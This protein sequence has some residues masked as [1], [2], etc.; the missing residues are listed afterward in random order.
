[1]NHATEGGGQLAEACNSDLLR[2][3]QD[4]LNRKHLTTVRTL[5][6]EE[7]VCEFPDRTCT[8]TDEIVA[9][10]EESFIAMP[11]RHVEVIAMVESGEDV[12]MRFRLT[13]TQD[14]PFGDLPATGKALVID[15]FEHFVM[16]DGRLV[17]SYAV[18][19]QLNVARQLGMIGPDG[20]VGDKLMKFAFRLKTNLSRR[21]KSTPAPG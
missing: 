3:A 5:C 17:C 4:E 7:T 2:K 21:L 18:S 20:S 9:Y 14:G 19:D 13:A 11:D 10:F 8:G 12:L 6:T 15:G 16:R 1:M